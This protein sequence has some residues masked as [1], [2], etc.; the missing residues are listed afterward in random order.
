M[1]QVDDTSEIIYRDNVRGKWANERIYARRRPQEKCVTPIAKGKSLLNNTTVSRPKKTLAPLR[2][3]SI[4][5]FSTKPTTQFPVRHA[6]H[7]NPQ[8]GDHLVVDH[9]EE[10]AGCF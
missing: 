5:L 2:P 6:T 1:Y 10:V 7:L 8:R 4:S 3:S 9:E